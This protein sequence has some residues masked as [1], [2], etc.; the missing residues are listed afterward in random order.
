M[1]DYEVNTGLCK[2]GRGVVNISGPGA[3]LFGA[4]DQL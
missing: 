3:G 1:K 4:A 2:L